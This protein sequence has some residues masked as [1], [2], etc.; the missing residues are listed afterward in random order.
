M[1]YWRMET[2]LMQSEI[3]ISMEFISIGVNEETGEMQFYAKDGSITEAP[4]DQD[5]VKLV[6]VI[7]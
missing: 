3:C 7:F 4:T 1:L 6:K 2:L 5:R